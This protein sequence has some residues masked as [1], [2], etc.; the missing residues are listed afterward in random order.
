MENTEYELAKGVYLSNYV[1]DKP[2]CD[3]FYISSDDGDVYIYM[4]YTD[5]VD[6]YLTLKEDDVKKAAQKLFPDKEIDPEELFKRTFYILG[7]RNQKLEGA[8]YKKNDGTFVYNLRD[9]RGVCSIPFLHKQDLS[10]DN[11]EDIE[12]MKSYQGLDWPT[13]SADQTELA[14]LMEAKGYPVKHY[15]RSGFE[16][17]NS[18]YIKIPDTPEENIIEVIT[19]INQDIADAK[20]ELKL[21]ELAQ[22]DKEFAEN[23]LDEDGIF[24][25]LELGGG[26]S[27]LHNYNQEKYQK[28]GSERISCCQD[29]R[30]NISHIYRVLLFDKEKLKKTDK[31]VIKLSSAMGLEDGLT[32]VSREYGV[33]FKIG[34]NTYIVNGKMLNNVS[35][36]DLDLSK[37]EDVEKALSQDKLEWPRI[38]ATSTILKEKLE[39]MGYVLEHQ[40]QSGI[41]R[42]NSYEIRTQ[43]GI[44]S[45]EAV[46]QINQDLE[47]AKNSAKEEKKQ[48]FD[49]YFDE[50]STDKAKV[51]AVVETGY[52]YDLTR[53]IDNEKYISIAKIRT[54]CTA[55]S[56]YGYDHIYQEL[57]INKE[58]IKEDKRGFIVLEVP[59]DMIG[60]VI[61]KGGCNIKALQQKFGKNFKVVQDPREIEAE[62]K[63]AEEERL[64]Q[65][66]NDLNSLQ[67]NIKDFIGNNLTSA[68]DESIAT[69][70]AEYITNN[71]DSLS[72][73]PTQEEMMQ[74]K[75]NLVIERDEQIAEENRRKAEE[76]AYQKRLKEE[77]LAEQKR[78]EEEKSAVIFAELKA[79]IQDWADTNN[80]NVISNTEFMKFVQEKYKEDELAQR[81]LGNLQ[82]ELLLKLE[83]ERAVRA[84]A[85]QAEKDF[86]K[87]A[88]TEFEKF[89]KDDAATGGHGDA[90]FYTVGKARR[91]SAYNLIAEKIERKLGIYDD[92]RRP[93]E[94]RLIDTRPKEDR[95]SSYL[96]EDQKFYD[97]IVEFQENLNSEGDIE[98][99]NEKQQQKQKEK[100]QS[101]QAEPTLENLAML[102][103][104]SL[105]KGNRK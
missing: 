54:S 70:M 82:R 39:N 99:Y 41:S 42:R 80:G 89:F 88:Q 30:R 59:K 21:K 16:S 22:A 81:L 64:R 102:W 52:N 46:A 75:E 55:D 45:P 104:V 43:D 100:A 4:S 58:R 91:N 60:L 96:D 13:F 65:R 66:K 7:S 74:I 40:G 44:I 38:N 25:Y 49:Q 27:D 8:K 86:D 3:G 10:F 28:I 23:I 53:T 72:V 5:E 50:Q 63:Q 33:N 67:R 37:P 29:N 57:I 71:Q 36:L 34:N 84:R 90:Y 97:R 103:G 48:A 95:W 85:I 83:E 94:E 51:Y 92:L 9:G 78:L 17:R 77:Q 87:V 61:G 69:S 68:D 47:Q 76:I 15:G 6:K 98:E 18:Y 93:L 24:S 20:E 32:D 79:H 11:P 73:H 12:V 101:Q 31:K 26:P 105:K 35:H 56:R 1:T 62:K 14:A 2:N 19:K